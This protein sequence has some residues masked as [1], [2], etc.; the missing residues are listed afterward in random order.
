MDRPPHD[1]PW[2]FECACMGFAAGVIFSMI[3]AVCLFA[4]Y[5]PH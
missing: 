5:S 4:A 1:I 2:G 3:V